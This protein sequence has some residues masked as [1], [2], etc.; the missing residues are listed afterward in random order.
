MKN[1]RILVVDDHD[2][3]RKGLQ[4][5]LGTQ[6]GCE[7]VGEAVDG[8]EAVEKAAQLKPDIVILDIRMPGIDGLEATPLILAASP[9]SE[10]L[11]FTLHHSELMERTALEAGARA[12]VRKSDA[13]RDL[14]AAVKA[15]SEQSTY[16][17]SRA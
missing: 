8:R 16:F 2:V 5:L 7:V 3:I 9:Q 12:Y 13:A 6:S 11:I 17:P 14:L 10:I 4:A 1:L 15:L